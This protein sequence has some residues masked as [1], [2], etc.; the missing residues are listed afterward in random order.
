MSFEIL[1]NQGRDRVYGTLAS[2]DT[3]KLRTMRNNTLRNC[4][5]RFDETTNRM[6]HVARI[7]G[8]TFINDAAARNPNATWYTLQNTEGPIIWIAFG[9]DNMADYARLRQLALR[10][11][12]MLICVGNENSLLHQTFQG[13]I[14][15]I[16]DAENI[17][18]AVNKACYSGFENVK[19]ILSPAT[20]QGLS[21]ETA[22]R[23][24]RHEVNEL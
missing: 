6:E 12:R 3:A 16:N 13:A 11:V 18:D 19:V 21:D 24:F 15:I 9:G 1:A 2:V 4:F 8:L 7:Y 23:Q 20:P 10:K 22:G 5:S 14:P 17:A